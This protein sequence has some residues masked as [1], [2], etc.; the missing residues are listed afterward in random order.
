MHADR[1]NFLMSSYKK[2]AIQIWIFFIFQMQFHLKGPYAL[3]TASNVG[4]GHSPA[5]QHGKQS[6]IFR[7]FWNFTCIRLFIK[8]KGHHFWI[9]TKDPTLGLV[10]AVTFGYTSHLYPIH[11]V[12]FQ[13]LFRSCY[14][15]TGKYVCS[16]IHLYIY[17]SFLCDTFSEYFHI[18][19]TSG[20]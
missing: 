15:V 10:S 19:V 17:F 13:N 4:K 8:W 11:Y 14:A 20:N 16:L 12:S 18:R 3:P 2:N 5:V 1:K 7:W 6:Y 9:R